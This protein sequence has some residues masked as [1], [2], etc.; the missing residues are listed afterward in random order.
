M[1]F[2]K[3]FSGR[4]DAFGHGGGGIVRSNLGLAQYAAHLDG[5]G[6]GLG[7]FPLMDDGTVYF[8]AIDLDEPN[9][10]LAQTLRDLL[11]GAE[12]IERT[13]SGN[14]HVWA[15]FSRRIEAWVARGIMRRAVEAVG[16]PQTEI[17]PKQDRLLPGM[18][19]NYINLPYHGKERPIL[20][21]ESL[22]SLPLDYFIREARTNDPEEWRER[23]RSLGIR[24]PAERTDQAEFGQQ[25]TLHEC[26]EYIIANRETNPIREG[27]RNI[28]YF[29]VAKQLLNW[30]GTDD[31]SAW[32]ALQMLE[33][34]S[35]DRMNP[36]E[37]RRIF[38][39]A[40]RGEYTSTGCD[41]P[42]MAPYVSPTCPIAHP[43]EG[44]KK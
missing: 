23:A 13:R 18:V 26:A 12:F 19:G 28:V 35:P 34:A 41:D 10:D 38:E 32:E 14:V 5:S 24:P 8:A 9:F 29:N 37:L 31:Y 1:P 15:F 4:D 42:A 27:Q 22:I 20:E 11:P 43:R 21:S 7:V 36:G 2:A 40:M 44:V 16:R 17:F 6:L 30:K 39:N 33:Q 3:L 25:E